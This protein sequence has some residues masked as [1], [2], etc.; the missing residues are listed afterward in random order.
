[1]REFNADL[2]TT[3]FFLP[4][5]FPLIDLPLGVTMKFVLPHPFATIL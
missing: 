2:H 5:Y 4:L 1:M 3:V